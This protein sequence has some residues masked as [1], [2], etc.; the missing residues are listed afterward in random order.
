MQKSSRNKAYV[1]IL[2]V[3]PA[4]LDKIV[5]YLIRDRHVTHVHYPV[6]FYKPSGEA[7]IVILNYRRDVWVAKWAIR[8]KN[9]LKGIVAIDTSFSYS[10]KTPE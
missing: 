4:M 1:A 3:D 9:K 8:I 5:D 7:L 6:S 10:Y 2:H